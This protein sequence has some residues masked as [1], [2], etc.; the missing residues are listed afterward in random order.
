MAWISFGVLP[1]RKKKNTWWQLASRCCWNRA[2]LLTCFRAC[3]LPDRA[4]GL[5]APPVRT[6][7]LHFDYPTA[8][9]TRRLKIIL[10]LTAYIIL[11]LISF[12]FCK[13]K[14]LFSDML[15]ILG[16][17]FIVKILLWKKL[18][19]DWGQE[20]LAIIQCRTFRLPGFYPK[21]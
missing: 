6:F 12:T 18:R 11:H 3:F 10:Y 20:M 1:C 2:R 17:T 7:F 8:I 5:S 9:Q 21:I 15:Y 19:A 13:I 14:N 16:S 4:K